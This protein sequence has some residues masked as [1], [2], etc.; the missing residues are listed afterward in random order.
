VNALE[1]PN[2]L[3]ALPKEFADFLANGRLAKNCTQHPRLVA[4]AG[5]VILL[6]NSS[7]KK[8]S[9]GDYVGG[10]M[11]QDKGQNKMSTIV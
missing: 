10:S 7:P 8:R 5:S 4:G 2:S 11:E 6:L 9:T 1:F 3:A